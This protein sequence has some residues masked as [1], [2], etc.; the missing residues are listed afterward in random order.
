MAFKTNTKNS[1]SVSAI[2]NEQGNLEVLPL[3]G[4]FF[5]FVLFLED[6]NFFSYT[7][8]LEKRPEELYFF[9]NVNARKK[10]SSDLI[11]ST[12]LKSEIAFTSSKNLFGVLRVHCNAT[13]PINLHLNF[14]AV[15][16]NWRYYVIAGNNFQNLTVD[17]TLAN[18]NFIKKQTDQKL[19]DKTFEAIDSNFPG[20]NL[21]VFESEGVI[22]YSQRGIKDIRL[23]NS[24]TKKTLIDHLPNPGYSEN[25][26]KIINTLN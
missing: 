18:I 26:I 24:D 4:Q 7:K 16:V 23:I 6:N 3:A 2:Q 22:P 1:V 8:L 10:T 20:C 5:E 12:I 11:A 21:F 25:G 13:F 14:D 15:D 17:G 19:A 9:T